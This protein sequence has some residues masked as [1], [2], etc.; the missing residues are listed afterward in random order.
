[1]SQRPKTCQTCGGTE[2]TAGRI[3]WQGYC[4]PCG[5]ARALDAA[6]QM[7][8]QQGPIYEQWLKSRGNPDYDVM[9]GG[10]TG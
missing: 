1:M 6:Y 8:T 4:A 9:Y 3:S 10:G 5:T 2:A 7:A